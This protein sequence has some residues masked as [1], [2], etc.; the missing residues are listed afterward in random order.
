LQKK[1]NSPEHTTRSFP[2]WNL[3]PEVVL[4]SKSTL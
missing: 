1:E 3:L 2:S 4:A